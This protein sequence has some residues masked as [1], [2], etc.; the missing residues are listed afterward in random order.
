[1]MSWTRI[2]RRIGLAAAIVIVVLSFAYI[3]TGLIWICSSA[4]TIQ[5]MGLEPGQ[6]FLAIL[7]AIIVLLCPA[8]V[9]LFGAIHAFAPADRKTLSLVAFALAVLVAGIPGWFT[10][11][12]L[13][14]SGTTPTKQ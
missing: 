13:R 5:A 9:A 1:M 7:E 4:S 6:P 14:L 8:L 2:D 12:N 10:S 3:V 11:C